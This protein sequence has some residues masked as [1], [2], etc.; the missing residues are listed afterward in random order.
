MFLGLLEQ[1]FAGQNCPVKVGVSHPVQQPG[2]YW[3]RSSALLL[4]GV[5][6]TKVTAY[7]QIPNLLTTRTLRTLAKLSN[8][9]QNTMNGKL[10]DTSPQPEKLINTEVELCLFLIFIQRQ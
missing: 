4:V 2:S 6:P 10:K 7:D 9:C 3:D 1:L 8:S 5:E